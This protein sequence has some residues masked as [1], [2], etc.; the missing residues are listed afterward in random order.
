MG[1][2][3]RVGRTVWTSA[4]VIP[5]VTGAYAALDAVGSAFGITGAVGQ[6]G[7]LAVA[8]WVKDMASGMSG[9]RFHF[10]NNVPP[11]IADNAPFCIPSGSE[12]GYQGYIDV[13]ASDWVTAGITGGNTAMH[14]R[15]LN[16]PL[17]LW[18]GTP[19]PDRTIYCQVQT[20]V[21]QTYGGM[22]TSLTMSLGVLQD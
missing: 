10:F 2:W 8:L 14:A 3:G 22:N 12:N 15:I 13:G 20:P 9:L 7:G 19:T 18:D 6:E 4:Q 16:Q 1:N 21:A 11:I 17:P 5:G